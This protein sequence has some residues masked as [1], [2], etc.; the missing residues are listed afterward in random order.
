MVALDSGEAEDVFSALSPATARRLLAACHEDP[1]TAS[2]LAERCDTSLQN[3]RY[4]LDKLLEAGLVDVVDTWYSSRGS[5][6]DVYGPTS[7]PIVVFP[8]D[9]PEETASLRDAL[10]TTVGALAVVGLLS[11]LVQW[12]SERAS[13]A[14]GDTADGP[15]AFETA[16]NGSVE[17]THGPLGEMGAW[18]G[19]L[20]PGALVLFGGTLA[21]AAVFLAW[22]WRTRRRTPLRAQAEG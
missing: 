19:G 13:P 6:M 1:A 17:A 11:L 2:D 10:S 18:L 15:Q 8:D 21:V 3:A 7:G 14:G 22:A 20:P 12:L 4:H 16:A 5:E 9:T